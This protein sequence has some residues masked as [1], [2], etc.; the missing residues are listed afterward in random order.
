MVEL[1]EVDDAITSVGVVGRLAHSSSW[2][3]T[4]LFPY[5]HHRPQRRARAH[6]MAEPAVRQGAQPAP[7]EENSPFRKALGAVQV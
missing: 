7:Q 6:K 4:E 1:V 3:P 2:W 5:N